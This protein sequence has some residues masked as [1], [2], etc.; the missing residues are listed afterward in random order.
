MAVGRQESSGRVLTHVSQSGLG[1]IQAEFR[2]DASPATHPWPLPVAQASLK[3]AS[4][5]WKEASLE[6]TSQRNQVG[7]AWVWPYS[8]RHSM[9]WICSILLV[10]AVRLP[11]WRGSL[12]GRN[13]KKFVTIKKIFYILL[14]PLMEMEV[15]GL[16]IPRATH[17]YPNG[18]VL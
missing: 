4:E 15:L 7:V 10:K 12:K 8:L 6:Q 9:I 16:Q 14:A 3:E 17:L 5:F 1:W 2:W 18:T 13:V 11:D